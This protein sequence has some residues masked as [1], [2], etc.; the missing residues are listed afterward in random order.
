MLSTRSRI[1][2]GTLASGSRLLTDVPSDGAVPRTRATG[3]SVA[4]KVKQ[5][6]AIRQSRR[7]EPARVRR[8]A[9]TPLTPRRTP[10]STGPTDPAA[11][12]C[13]VHQAS[14]LPRRSG[15]PPR[16][17][18]GSDR[19]CG[20]A[21]PQL[22]AVGEP[23]SERLGD[24]ETAGAVAG[25]DAGSIIE[26]RAGVERTKPSSSFRP[27]NRCSTRWRCRAATSS[28]CKPVR[29]RPRSVCPAVS[30]ST[31]RG[32][33]CHDEPPDVAP[34]AKRLRQTG[35]VRKSVG[36]STSEYCL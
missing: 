2:H 12:T 23:G 17:G 3:A 15:G 6:Q 26:Q 30:F 31:N 36:R 10:S 13:L 35:Y 9:A 25:R 19:R 20:S 34:E 7:H 29:R 14:A 18:R 24:E 16:C 33:W 32:P 5:H 27:R 1:R 21:E 4:P 22:V 11:T 8:Q 28:G